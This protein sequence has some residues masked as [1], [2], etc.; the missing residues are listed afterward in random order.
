MINSYN[1]NFNAPDAHFDS[2]YLFSDV[3]VEKKNPKCYDYKDRLKKNQNK[4]KKKQTNKQTKTKNKKKKKKK[5]KK[6]WR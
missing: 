1:T 4:N 3:Q 5:K 2:S 6:N